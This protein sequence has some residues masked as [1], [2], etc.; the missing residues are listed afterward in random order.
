MRE[1]YW[2]DDAYGRAPGPS[3]VPALFAEWLSDGITAVATGSVKQDVV[4]RASLLYMLLK[5]Q[6]LTPDVIPYLGGA[7]Y[8][9]LPEY[10]TPRFLSADKT[11][12]Q[13]GLALLNLRYGIQ[14]SEGIAY[15]TIGWGM[16]A[17]AFANFGYIGVF[18]AA[19]VFGLLSALFTRL[20]AGAAP[21]AL[22]NLLS[23]AALVSLTNL[24]ADFGYLLTNLWQALVGAALFFVPLKYLSSGAESRTVRAMA[25]TP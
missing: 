14:T 13:A 16:I 7:T 22:A 21:L 8:A 4:D 15:T 10:L 5:V 19:V 9:L 6:Y 3:R 23:V 11:F 12:S 17:E 1:H 18:G 24:E 2:V 20:S 25:A